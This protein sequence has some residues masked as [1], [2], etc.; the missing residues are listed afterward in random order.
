[1]NYNDFRF[2]G[3]LVRSKLKD[4]NSPKRLKM[5]QTPFVNSAVLLLI[6]PIEEKPYNIVMI[7]RTKRMNDKHSGEM[8][9][10][11]GKFDANSDHTLL[12]TALREVNEEIGISRQN[13]IILGCI[14]DHLTPKGY[15]ITPFVG[16]VVKEL[17]FVKQKEEVNEI[18][19]I[20]INFFANKNNY[21]EKTY[22]IKGDQ[23]AVGKFKYRAPNGRL[24]VIFGATSHIIV[25]YIDSVYNVGLMT[26]GSR[27][28]KCND[29]VDKIIRN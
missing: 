15:I 13:I 3:D 7:R 16:Y 22:N 23:I 29:I 26:P 21:K 27:R 18:V 10:P 25:N 8:S 20:P 4:F 19:K 1:M 6:Q 9:F 12:D 17:D 24:Y 28:I 14:D 11:G 2:H 5:Q